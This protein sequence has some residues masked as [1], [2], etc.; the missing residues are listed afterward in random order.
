MQSACHPERDGRADQEHR[1]FPATA[2]SGEYPAIA[3]NTPWITPDDAMPE[4]LTVIWRKKHFPKVIPTYRVSSIL[5]VAE[6]VG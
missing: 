1:V 5:T 3:N 4:H 2:L 6:L